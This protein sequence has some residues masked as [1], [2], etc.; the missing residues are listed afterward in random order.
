MCWSI[1][2]G[3]EAL[4]PRTASIPRFPLAEGEGFEPPW[5]F[6]PPVFKLAAWGPPTFA[7]HR[8]SRNILASLSAC[9]RHCSPLTA[10]VGVTVGVIASTGLYSQRGT[11]Q[12]DFHVTSAAVRFRAH[13]SSVAD[14]GL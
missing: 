2:Q 7:Y 8:Q 1:D 6:R 9:V 12:R 10:W 3:F 4:V 13:P 14:T 5:A 11:F